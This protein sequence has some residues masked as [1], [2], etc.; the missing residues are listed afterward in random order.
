MITT[1]KDAGK[2]FAKSETDADESLE[3]FA[4]ILGDAPT[5][6]HFETCRIDWLNGYCEIKPN[7]KGASADVAFSR[8]KDRLVAKYNLVVPSSPNKAATKKREERATKQADLIAKYENVD[9]DEI[10]DQ[11]EQVYL[12]L[13]KSPSSKILKAQC[14]ELEQVIRI[15]DKEI[16]DQIKDAKAT[17]KEKLAECDDI[18]LL[19]QVIK[20]LS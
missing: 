19:E 6:D 15:K 2:L 17:I 11:I 18:G 8:C 4:R 5:Y 14:R 7:A 1:S 16:I 13:A 9:S 10:H 12:D 20:L 3:C